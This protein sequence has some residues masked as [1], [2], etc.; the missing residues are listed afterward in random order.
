MESCA[1]IRLK[2]GDLPNSSKNLQSTFAEQ[3]NAPR[4][5]FIAA[6]DI[7]EPM[8][9]VRISGRVSEIS[10]TG[11]YI[12]ILN[13]LPVDTVVNLRIVR[14]QGTFTTP[15]KIVYVQDRMGMGIVFL[16]PLPAQL[17]I[18]DEWLV[19]LSAAG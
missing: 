8:S 14:D 13:A 15:G 11:C 18:L 12:D 7:T 19:E 6:A 1:N 2:M 9:G 17:Q 3:R 10:R 5:T 4:F 16:N